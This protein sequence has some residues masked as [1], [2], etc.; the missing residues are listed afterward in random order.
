MGK[1]KFSD[2]FRRDAVAQITERGYPVDVIWQANQ[3]NPDEQ[4]TIDLDQGGCEVLVIRPGLDVE[5]RVLKPGVQA[6]LA[7][8]FDGSDITQAYDAAVAAHE[9]FD[10]E[11]AMADLIGGGTFAAC[12]ET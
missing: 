5:V 8:L 6:L 3:R 2:D 12:S 10:F 1:A 7:A 9:N 4:G 11:G